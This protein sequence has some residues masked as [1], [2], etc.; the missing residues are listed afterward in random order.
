MKTLKKAG[1]AVILLALGTIMGVLLARPTDVV[2]GQDLAQR[3]VVAVSPSSCNVT[4]QSR[5]VVAEDGTASGRLIAIPPSPCT[6]LTLDIVSVPENTARCEQRMGRRRVKR[7][8]CEFDVGH[9]ITT[10]FFNSN[11]R[12]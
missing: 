4:V 3:F 12:D 8:S 2:L 7:V 10:F 1:I 6:S 11:A 5:I 9:Q